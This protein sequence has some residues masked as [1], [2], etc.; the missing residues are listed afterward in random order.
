MEIDAQWCGSAATRC[1]SISIDGPERPNPTAPGDGLFK[2]I[3]GLGPR[4]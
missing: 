3:T 1:A 4:Q 2:P